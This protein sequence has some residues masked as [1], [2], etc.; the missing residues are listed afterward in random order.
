[1]S[2]YQTEQIA[3]LPLVSSTMPDA[4]ALLAVLRRLSLARSRP[5]IMEIVTH[6]ARDLLN[7]D[8]IT[9]VLREGDLCHYAEEDALSPL[10]KG[11]RFPMKACISG[12]CM[13]ERRAVAVEDIYKDPRI[14][15]EAYHS[16]F[17]R[18]LALV[19]VR[20]DNPIAAMG[21]YWGTVRKT[22]PDQLELLQGVA[23]AAG[24][25]L[26]NVELAEER[27]KARKAQRELGHRIRN[28]LA[29]IHSIFGQTLRTTSGIA[30]LAHAFSGR[31][32]ALARAQAMLSEPDGTGA[33]LRR[34]IREQLLI[35][36]CGQA[37]ACHGPNVFLATDEAFE[38][39]LA[40]H[41]LGTNAR[42][43]GALSTE[44]GTVTIEWQVKA[45]GG[46]SVLDFSWRE[47]GG[48]PVEPPT[49]T[50]M[51]SAFLRQA[52]RNN[53]GETDIRY[54]P[55]GVVCTMRIPLR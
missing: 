21:A 14:P 30:E 15:H 27:E 17:V 43:Y 34:L 50:G 48:P 3:S 45:E 32:Q 49:S 36:E 6:A 16:T 8:G 52:F 51:G 29:V 42:K 33:D 54:E 13:I 19:P 31:L 26:A 11:R 37:V 4:S 12:V 20:Q 38:L 41:E 25:A 5:E 39:G 2:E 9:F 47:Q 10:W 53:G 1:M 40:L 23:N 35:P 44:T 7:T 28:L 55:G 46:C 18:S 24:L 22:S